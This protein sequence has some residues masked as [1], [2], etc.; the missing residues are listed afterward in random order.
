MSVSPDG[1]YV[2]QATDA[3]SNAGLAIY[4]VETAPVCQPA[5]VKTAFGTPVSVSLT[6]QDADG[7]AVT[8]SIV[9]APAPG[10]LGAINNAAGTVTYTP[11]AGFSG[12]DRFTFA[13]SDGVNGSAPVTATIAVAAAPPSLTN[14]TVTPSAFFAAPFGPSVARV[15]YGTT[16]SYS[17]SR[18]ATTTLTVLQAQPGVKRGGKCVAPPRRPTKHKLARCTRTVVLGSFTHGD[19]AG[20]NRFRFTGRV[21]H[22]ALKPGR[23]TLRATASV[24]GLNGQP[25]QA[26][27][28]IKNK[29]PR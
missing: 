8:R 21:S 5:S 20:L 9:S 15:R 24:G 28:R 6:C 26:S 11:A 10:T 4:R 12:T 22:H 1:G 19:V 25:V 3:S 18:A 16:V 7:D 27:F 29:K 13:G 23:Y 17:G 14:L 2:Y